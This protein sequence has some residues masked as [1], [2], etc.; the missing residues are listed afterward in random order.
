MFDTHAHYT[1]RRFGEDIED[2]LSRIDKSDEI[3][4]IIEASTSIEDSYKAVELAKSNKKFFA[5][6]GIH[7]SDANEVNDGWET[8]LRKLAVMDKVVGIGEIGLDYHYD[9]VDKAIQ[10]DVL[11]RQL[12]IAKELD[13]P[14]VIHDREAHGDVIDI[15]LE[16]GVR[17]VFH[18]Y[19]GSIDSAKE[20]LRGGDWYFSFN[21][22]VTFKNAPKVQ[23]VVRFLPIDRILVETDCPYLAP[24]PYRGKRN[25]SFLMKETIKMIAQLKGLS[26]DEVEKITTENAFRLFTK[27]EKYI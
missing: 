18:C 24:V 15:C 23:E 27:M 14:V 9:D 4:Y 16:S 21:G 8:E 22:V 26:F 3:E 7:P 20:L 10:K 1:D 19:S 6:V 2:I 17:G 11:L 12:A 13:L 5:V 25:D